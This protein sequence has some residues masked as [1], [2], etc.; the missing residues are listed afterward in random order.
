MRINYSVEDINWMRDQRIEGKSWK[1]IGDYIGTSPEAARSAVRRAGTVPLSSTPTQQ[2]VL[3]ADLDHP[4]ILELTKDLDESWEVH[5]A[6]IGK[7][8]ADKFS[9]RVWARRHEGFVESR[10]AKQLL[11]DIRAQAPRVEPEFVVPHDDP[12]CLEMAPMDVHIGKL[13]WAAEVGDNYDSKIACEEYEEAVEVLL[14][15][16]SGFNL[17]QIIIPIGND[18][19]HVDNMRS[20][21][22]A[23]TFQDT[24]TRYIYMFRRA[25]QLM[26]WA[27][28][29]C[30]EVAPV[31]GIIV[32]GN[33]DQL[34]SF[35]IGEVLEAEF[36]GHP[37]I[38]LDNG[39]SLRKYHRYGTNLIGFTHGR[40]EKPNMLPTIMATEAKELWGQ[41]THHEWHIGHRHK[42]KQ[43]QWV[44]VDTF[45]GVIV[46]TLPSLSSTDS[47][48][49]QQGYQPHRASEAYLWHPTLGYSG[50]FNHSVQK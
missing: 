41:T 49:Y 38:T 8:A 26:S 5:R 36:D 11:E 25:R 31:K 22:T 21:T 17:D 37:N 39:P 33:H 2:R 20:T 1:E 10:L 35:H 40:D 9:V 45:E 14:R 19:L 43:V 16:S 29:R 15:K 12:H 32:P 3:Q 46:R 4:S 42:S 50:H 28:R 7:T 34:A 47:W 23:G 44:G 27:L 13:A 24:D 48:H 18:L 6:S 30:A